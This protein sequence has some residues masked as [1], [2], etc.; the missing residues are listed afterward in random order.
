MPEIWPNLSKTMLGSLENGVQRLF[1][2][3]MTTLKIILETAGGK[4][5]ECVLGIITFNN[6]LKY[7]IIFLEKYTSFSVEI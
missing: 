2:L 1:H 6:Q 4:M 3:F 5:S 7:K